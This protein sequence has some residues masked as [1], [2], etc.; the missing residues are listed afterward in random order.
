MNS[1]TGALIRKSVE[2][3]VRQHLKTEISDGWSSAPASQGMPRLP[4]TT[5][6]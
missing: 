6:N 2:D 1:M 5:R 3:T 4:A